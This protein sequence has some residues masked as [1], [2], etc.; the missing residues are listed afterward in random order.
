M[1]TVTLHELLQPQ[2]ILDLIS[3]TKPGQ[4]KLGRWLGFQPN[5][6]D[7]DTVSLSGPAT[8][9]GQTRYVR[10]N[11]FNATRVSA[12]GRAPATGPSV[13][14]QN[15]MATVPVT[16]ARFHS[17]IPLNYELL[18]NLSPMIGPNSQIDSMG[19]DYVRQQSVNL[20]RVFAYNVE[21]MSAG[22]LRGQF[23]MAQ[24]GDNWNPTLTA[25]GGTTP[26]ITVDFKIPAANKNQLNMLGTGNIITIPWNNTSAPILTN[27]DQIKAAF[28]QIHGYPL[29]HV[30]INSTMRMNILNNTQVRNVGGSANTSFAEYERVPEK[31][32]DGADM[33]NEYTM[34]LRADPTITWHICDDTV[35]TG[36]NLIDPS[37]STSTA[38]L[39][40]LIPDDMAI[41]S[42]E[43]SPDIAK[44]F[45]GGEPVVENPGQPATIRSGYYFWHEYR[46]QPSVVELIALLNALPCLY[47]PLVIAPATVTG[48]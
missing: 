8:V 48:F 16:C 20:A 47:N 18:G 40:K 44:M 34:V 17:K 35:A 46:T 10:Y 27:L 6:F 23:Y 13:L 39:E 5:R 1:A 3:R 45:L 41:F 24:Q 28:A 14:P 7:K 32:M 38:S 36:G 11:I 9:N 33:G 19:Q 21:L 30:W 12:G 2:V 15:P 43:P 26:T 31:G 4:G 29:K 25:P 37:Y 22:M 42:T